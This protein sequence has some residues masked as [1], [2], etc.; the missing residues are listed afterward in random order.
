MSNLHGALGFRYDFSAMWSSVLYSVLRSGGMRILSNCGS[1]QNQR[2]V[3]GWV[4]V[5][6]G[7]GAMLRRRRQRRV[8]ETDWKRGKDNAAYGS[9]VLWMRM[10]HTIPR[11]A[12][13]TVIGYAKSSS[14]DF[15]QKETAA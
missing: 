15:T 2:Q 8:F 14:S 1:V 9:S 4:G 11:F 10:T 13:T 12:A 7:T 5:G 3:F 6:V